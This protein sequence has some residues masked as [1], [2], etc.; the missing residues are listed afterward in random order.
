SPSGW[1]VRLIPAHCHPFRSGWSAIGERAPCSA[2]IERQ[3]GVPSVRGFL[4]ASLFLPRLYVV[5]NVFEL[6]RALIDIE[7]ITNNEERVGNYLYDY[8]EPL[9]ARFDGHLERIEVE[10]RRFNLFAQWGE[11]LTVTLSTH[12]DTVP[13][14]I[15]SREDGE[16]I[17]GRGACDTKG[18]IASM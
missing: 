12:M 7:S 1:G 2:G 5:M 17:W 13:P 15:A 11:A 3:S 14:Y 8:L 4:L 16:S 10:P 9:A 6:T 18:L